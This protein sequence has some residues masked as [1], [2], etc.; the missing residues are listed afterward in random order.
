MTVPAQNGIPE[1][2]SL[3]FTEAERAAMRAYLQRCEVRL[4]T[5]HRIATAFL[6][7]AGLILLIPIFFKD[8]IDN[9]IVILLADA[10]N[11]FIRL[12]ET[13]GMALTVL[14]YV[15]VC[16][17]LL[18]SLVI[19]VYA[20][21]LLLKDIVH[22][23]FTIY[24][25]GFSSTLLNPTFAL[26]GIAFSWDESL[27]AKREIIRYQYQPGKLNY[28]V[29]FSM[30]RRGEYFDD[31]FEQTSGEII[32]PSRRIQQLKAWDALPEDVDLVALKHFNAAFGLARTLDRAL[33]EEV[34]QMEM[35]LARHI[36]YLRRLLL[37]YIKA[38]LMF[39]WTML[40]AFIMLP[41]LRDDRLHT[42]V[43]LGFGYLI[44]GLAVMRIMNLPIRW[45]Y[46]HRRENSTPQ[47]VDPQLTL[48]E[49]NVGK[50][51]TWAVYTSAA[52]LILALVSHI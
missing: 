1:N 48:L 41:F 8:V 5:L 46:R 2:A 47:H 20:V 3:E 24:V 9:I 33:V 23:Y 7:G 17:P 19:P 13:P 31:L 6:S 15:L 30:E 35:A 37:R 52:G 36:L 34:A 32:P 11:Q 43:L 40:I 45:I 49:R 10:G 14:M 29:P 22:F 25:P 39:I 12:G 21:I 38:L 50:Y 4:S 26:T 42:F 51:C 18:L 44:W 16:Y 28:M 27:K